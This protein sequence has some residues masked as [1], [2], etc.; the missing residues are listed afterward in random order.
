MQDL[1]AEEATVAA[2][3]FTRQKEAAAAQRLVVSRHLEL[4]QEAAS[5]SVPP[6]GHFPVLPE[7]SSL[8]PHL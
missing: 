5:A 3:A 2:M 7:L 6:L 1:E 8:P 4:L